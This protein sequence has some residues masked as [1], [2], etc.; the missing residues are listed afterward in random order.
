MKFGK[1][2]SH[3]ITWNDTPKRLTRSD[4]RYGAE[5]FYAAKL[6]YLATW[7]RKNVDPSRDIWLWGAGRITRKRFSPLPSHGI[8]ITGLIDIDPKK[9][10]AR[11]D[12]LNVVMPANMPHRDKVFIITG[13]AKHGARELIQRNLEDQGRIEGRD[14]I[15]AA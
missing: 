14:F 5:K 9:C 12:G 10:G 1:V 3:V 13:V 4:P 7:L 11:R 8:S 15:H 6:A 2:G